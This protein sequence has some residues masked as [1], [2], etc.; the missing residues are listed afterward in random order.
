MTKPNLAAVKELNPPSLSEK[1]YQLLLRKITRLELAPGAVLAERALMN[2]LNI[3]RT[4]IREALQRLASEG[5]VSHLPNRGMFVTEIGATSVQ[6]IYEFRAMIEGFTARLA[7]SR[8]T[9]EEIAELASLHQQLAGATKK[10][11]IDLYVDL[12]FHFHVLLAQASKNAYLEEVVPRIFYLHLRLWFFISSRTG[13]WRSIADA[14]DGMTDGV[15][16][17]LKSRD[18]DEAERAMQSYISLR[19]TDIKDVL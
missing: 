9:E 10:N 1:A 6:Q 5:L 7:A 3:G 17:A 15:V 13:N 19:H 18:P 8:A 16:K 4:P 2:E 11:D 14:H 12:D